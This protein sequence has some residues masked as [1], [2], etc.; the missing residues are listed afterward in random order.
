MSI[1]CLKVAENPLQ[2]SQMSEQSTPKASNVVWQKLHVDRKSRERLMGQRG[3]LLWFTGLSASGKST[4][5]SLV[6]K[7]LHNMGRKTYLLDGDNVRHGLCGDLGFSEEDRAEN[8]RRIAEVGRL[9]VDAGL[10]A[11]VA[12]I[13][14]YQ[15]DRDY[16][17][18]R[19]AE[20]EL[21]EIFVDTPVEVCIER[22][23]KGLYK[24]AL[25]GEVKNFT[26]ISAP[27]EAPES[28]EVRL[29][30]QELSVEEA[31]DM[32][33]AALLEAEAQDAKS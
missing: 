3:R 31:A 24:R 23:P 2:T 9:M 5:A 14:P 20:G 25:S 13:S 15:R 11:I 29:P 4:I 30:T 32:V 8:V 7:K 19:M 12:L 28:P 26:G 16:V 10:I 18:S 17:R 27:Y 22:D 21:I 1:H 6:D 33:V